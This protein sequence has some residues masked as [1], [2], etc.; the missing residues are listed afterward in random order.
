MELM[1]WL[2]I[3]GRYTKMYLDYYL[4]PLGL[5]S[6]QHMYLRIIC[7]MPGI[8]QDQ[9]MSCFHIHPS[10]ITRS[11][12]YL[13]KQGFLKRECNASDRRTSC[14]YPTRLGIEANEKII[15]ICENWKK[16]IFQEFTKEEVQEMERYLEK[17][18]MCIMK[19][20]E[21]LKEE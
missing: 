9:L 21:A 20:V 19:K 15:S 16:E 14:L 6:S 3:T 8:A 5:N 10:N 11:I 17:A 18:G 7:Q 12:L 1:K 4:A 13:E 2:S